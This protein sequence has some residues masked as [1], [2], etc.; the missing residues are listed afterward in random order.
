MSGASALACLVIG[1][2]NRFLTLLSN[3]KDFEIA[4]LLIEVVRLE[5]ETTDLLLKSLGGSGGRSGALMSRN[6]G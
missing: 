3:F 6:N 4:L 2:G 5:S 1:F